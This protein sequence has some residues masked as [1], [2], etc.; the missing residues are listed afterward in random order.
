MMA[1][2]HIPA[3]PARALRRADAVVLGVIL[4]LEAVSGF[5]R[6]P[7]PGT[8]IVNQASV[9]YADI[10]G[11][12][13]TA[14]SPVVSSPISAAPRLRLEKSVDSDPVAPG[15]SFHYTISF[16]NT[17]NTSATNVTVVDT[18]PDGVT[19]QSATGSFTQSGRTL[20]WNLGTLASGASGS[21]VVTVQAQAGLGAGTVLTNAAS[22][23]S[24]EIPAESAS[25]STRIGAGANL[26]LVK[27][28]DPAAVSAGGVITYRLA[29]RNL[30]NLEA[31]SVR[32]ADLIPVGTAYVAGSA[33]GSPML[34]GGELIWAFGTLAP[35]AKGE[36]GFQVRVS[37]LAQTG[38]QI[39][40][41]GSIVSAS[42][43]GVSNTVVTII[44][45]AP[46]RTPGAVAFY[47]SAWRPV[48]GYMD[49]ERVNVQV[50][51]HDQNL[52]PTAVETI[53]VVVDDLKTG[54]TETLV[55]TETGPDTGVFRGGLPSVIGPA[56][57]NDGT[58]SVA[59][60]TRIRA[61]YTD[62]LDAVPVVIALAMID[63]R[64]TV[65]DSVTGE[66]IAGAV[67]TLRYWDN[68][69]GTIDLSRLPELPEGQVN[70]ALPTGADGKFAF[71]LAPAGD[72][73]YELAPP[74]GYAWPSAVP[75]AD[76]P[77]G[78]TIGN[79]S[80]G[81]KFTL[82]VG[83]P[84]LI[85]DIPLDPP[86]GTLSI[87]K[88][89]SKSAASIGDL[90]AYTLA[91]T[92]HGGAPVKGLVVTDVM[93]R[94]VELLPGSCRLDGK[95]LPDP[96]HG[97][98]RTF[99]WH[100]GDLAPSGVLEITYR[101][102]V[103][104][105]SLKG[106][107]I[108]TGSA[109]GTCFGKRV[110]SNRASVHLKLTGGVFTEK[111]T[112]LGKVFLDRDGNRIQNAADAPEPGIPQVVLYLEDGTR[113]ITDRNG[114][115]S[116]LGVAPGNHV[117]RIDEA[118]IPAGLHPVPL[119][120]RFL[121]EGSSQFVD[122]EPGGLCQADFALAGEAGAVQ[123]FE[124]ASR[125]APAP[126]QAVALPGPGTPSSTSE[127]GSAFPAASSPVGQSPLEPPRPS[128]RDWEQEIKTMKPGLAF[129][130]PLDGSAVLQETI[131]VVLKA[132]HGTEPSLTLNGA[133]VD[134]KL[135]GRRIDFPDGQVTLFEYLDIH[136]N[137]GEANLLRAEVKD[138]FGIPRGE[139]RASVLAAGAPDRILLAAD[140][141]EVPADGSS[142]IQVSVLLQDKRGMT[143][144]YSGLA[145]VTA[146]S[147][148]LLGKDAD[149]LADD[150]QISLENGSASFGLQAPRETGEGLVTV[151][152]EGRE[153]TL[154]VFFSPHLRNLFVTGLG[155]VVLGHGGLGGAKGG[156]DASLEARGAFF[157]KGKVHGDY[158][159][160]AAYDS[161]KPR[162]DALFRESDTN[163][164]TEDKY[165]IYGDESKTGYEAVSKGDL[166]VKV[167]KNRSYLLFGDFRTGLD[168][169]WLSAYNRA[170]NGLKYE[171]NT[172]RFK[173][174]SFA[175]YTDQTQVVDTL[176]GKGI[177]GYYTLSQHPIV[178]GS[179]HV[180]I[181]VRDRQSTSTVLSRTS[182][183]RGSD[184]EIDSAFGSI[185]FKSPVPSY[186]GDYNPVFI[187]V[188][189][190]STAM[191][192][193]Y[194]T[195][196]GRGAFRPWRWLE[197]GAT[198]IVEEKAIG[199]YHLLG[200]DL[201]LTLPRKTVLKAEYAET[202]SAFESSGLYEWRNG[203]GLS[204]TAEGD[205]FDKLHV[206]A[207]YRQLSDDYMNLSTVEASR[208]TTRYGLD[209]S[210]AISKETQFR[211]HFLDERNGLD[212]TWHRIVS[213]GAQSMFKKT[214][215]TAEVARESM[216]AG[217]V[218][219]DPTV[220]TPFDIRQDPPRDL[221][222]LKLAMETA[223]RP[224]LSLN[225][226]HKQNLD[227]AHYSSTQAG[228]TYQINSLNRAYLRE[229][230]LNTAATAETRTLVGVESQLIKNTVAFNEYRL[231]DGAD[232]AR[233]QSVIGLRN[234]FLIGPS[235]TASVSGE[236]LKTLHG[237]QREGDPDSLAATAGLEYLPREDVK[238]TG[239]VEHRRELDRDGQHSWLG[240][241]GLA[242]KLNPDY[243][244]LFT[245]R[246][247]TEAGNERGRHDTSRTVAGLAYRPLDT[248]R[249]NALAKLE[250]RQERNTGATPAFRDAAYILSV[251]GVYQARPGLQMSA[252]YAGKL[253]RDSGFHAYTDLF[254]GRVFCDLA[255]RWDV[256]AECR[257]LTS[258]DTGSRSLGGSAEIGRRLMTNVW[259]SLGY[260]LD[261][262]DSDLAGDSYQGKGPFLRLRFKFDERDLRRLRRA[263]PTP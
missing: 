247:F 250:F 240:E 7:E 50:T 78:F 103:G 54:D 49:G 53:T 229:E 60:D 134:A 117:L 242:F 191:G 118:T 255:D 178:E 197:L 47:S 98:G 61:T 82:Q 168:E 71:P 112:I 126:A 109:A 167:E 138:P 1:S 204:F 69:T 94:G 190:E 144:P 251:E 216:N 67:V 186:D 18:L 17:G 241:A 110:A 104:P 108:N 230:Y 8:P 55:L 96:D 97:G 142:K 31:Q 184:Y 36:V 208:G 59:R 35:G 185:L 238:V 160:T 162:Q 200:T 214:K 143:V 92:N 42:Q 26:L 102:V 11:N 125:K 22:I 150:F 220:H 52:D 222:S 232:G 133:P 243:S 198:G 93:P 116:I 115:Y 114:K 45:S 257:L 100:V 106:D 25:V 253:S 63:P 40:N 101:A 189:Y 235:T 120:S 217:F 263:G 153:E 89:A 163:L 19:F 194:Y 27:T 246:Y 227:G 24:A 145:T 85:R 90:V 188:S 127:S 183:N 14:E 119:S 3:A 259:L 224:D 123:A 152:V 44:S 46:P 180:V 249:F 29:Y 83:D 140:R 113:V 56:S 262:F 256:G 171:L 233:T 58:L 176:P 196:G 164:G 86:P 174:R 135:I 148:E 182:Q 218:P 181:E 38:S 202:R 39:S 195:Y 239:R 43:A 68:A 15:A 136:L 13:L 254:A 62:P 205:P 179:E 156:S 2:R 111:G 236:Y 77:S 210:Y 28:A 173:V 203:H 70:P 37:T 252:K 213:L 124:L 4:C 131:R 154:K 105:G 146:S 73:G 157:L 258:H 87:T 84:P 209:A 199:N 33:T 192:D 141:L 91:V 193:K 206:N 107:G 260:S 88:T 261:R 245:E 75:D 137:A 21:L 223:L 237:T 165:P 248:N 80:R 172:D 99:T 72:Y 79:G 161:D 6:S 231:A 170:F 158:L 34:Q 64:G 211:S 129:L 244:L 57:N 16:E 147:G 212:D 228:M 221:S 149:P 23:S 20:T 66:P 51:D 207:F 159:L 41:L 122:M 175:S 65:F 219:V 234:K 151:F 74:S 81:E 187:V 139:A 76:L 10:H 121:G 32:V 95:P 225:L 169:T 166:Y 12:A 155:E 177:S 201:T 5:A 226:S 128:A 9:Q 130:A 48:I 215:L 132:P 30:G